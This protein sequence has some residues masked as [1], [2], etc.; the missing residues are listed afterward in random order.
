MVGPLGVGLLLIGV[1]VGVYCFQPRS[2]SG[3]PAAETEATRP[4]PQIAQ[5]TNAARSLKLITWSFD[6]TLDAR[7]VSDRWYG[8]ATAE[9]RAPVRYQ[10]GVDLGTLEPKDAFF[11]SAGERFV[12]LVRP[13]QR[14]SCEIDV[15]QLEQTLTTSGLR[16]RS[17]NTAKIDEARKIL[18][19]RAQDLLL[20]AA[21]EGRLRDVS[22][23]Q[24]EAH[25][26]GV[27]SRVAG[28][29]ANVVV[30]FSD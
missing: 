6:T 7:V 13:P 14:L 29:D 19:T 12:F 28:I 20:S 2:V 1:G 26:R 3:L 11:D 27:L 21:D 23:E 9:V 25:L 10:Y 8:E 15:A 30:R 16:W 22:R 17:S 5:I 24:L 18:A 4:A